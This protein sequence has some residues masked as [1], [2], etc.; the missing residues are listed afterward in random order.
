VKPGHHASVLPSLLLGASLLIAFGMWHWAEDIAAPGYTAQ[1]LAKGRPIGN[2]SDLYPRWLGARE[3]LLHGR[4]PYSPEVTREI[5]IGFYGRPLNPQNPS[6]P[7][8]PESFVYPL[9]VVFLLAPTLSLRF[10]TVQEIFR[11]L[12]LFLLACSVPVWMYAIRFQTRVM[13]TVAGMVLAVSSSAAIFEYHQQNLA[14]FVVFMLAAAAAAAVRG[15]MLLA[16]FLLALSTIKPELSALNVLWFLLW[17]TGCWV[18]R[19][20]LVFSFV[21]AMAA[22]FIAA[23][24]VSPHWMGKFLSALREYPSYGSDP[25]IL[26]VFLPSF[27]AK[28]AAA[29]LIGVLVVLSW[30][31]RK[32]PAGSEYFGWALAWVSTV[33]LAVLPKLAPYNQSLLIPALLVVLAN[34]EKIQQSGLLPRALAKGVFA[35]LMWQWLTS[36]LL[37]LSTFLVPV[38]RLRAAVHVPDYTSIAVPPLTLLTVAATTFSLFVNSTKVNSTKPFGKA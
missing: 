12:L 11:W 15:W 37:S 19:K 27:L 26:R 18:E 29:G 5:Q 24:V 13:F 14:M 30:Q 10:E 22:L 7:T 1:A 34:R 36:L 20:R 38:A 35:C 28:A 6:D 16:G 33:T 2:N 23:E 9:Y 3:L 17:A 32:A 25:S 31:W 8:V 4:D 21:G